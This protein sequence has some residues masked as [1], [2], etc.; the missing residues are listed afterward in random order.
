M[1]RKVY[2]AGACRNVLNIV[3]VVPP[4]YSVRRSSGLVPPEQRAQPADRSAW[5]EWMT[6]LRRSTSVSCASVIGFMDRKVYLGVTRRGILNTA[7]IARTL[8]FDGDI[9]PAEAL[10]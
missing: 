8:E 2:L 10:P 5:G 7:P 6:I 9:A 1:A 3:R 4:N